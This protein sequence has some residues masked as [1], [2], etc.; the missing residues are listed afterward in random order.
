MIPLTTDTRWRLGK[1]HITLTPIEQMWAKY[2]KKPD[3][4]CSGC[5][6]LARGRVE[7]IC[8]CGKFNHGKD[9]IFHGHDPACGA[10]FA[11]P[12]HR[13]AYQTEMVLED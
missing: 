3:H 4:P 6:F 7:T 13:T 5:A 10:Y 1:I 12:V 11:K 2:G 8:R 9:N